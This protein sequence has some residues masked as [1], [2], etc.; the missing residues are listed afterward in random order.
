[1]PDTSGFRRDLRSDVEAAIAGLDA[2]IDVTFRLNE[3]GIRQQVRAALAGLDEAINVRLN[4]EDGALRADL[5]ALVERAQAGVKARVEVTWGTSATQLRNELRLL[6]ARAQAGVRAEVEVV[7]DRTRIPDLSGGFGGG[8]GF[9]SPGGWLQI[10]G[11]MALATSLAG[12]LVAAGAAVT[13]AWGAVS[14]TIAAIPVAIAAIAIPAAT[15]FLGFDELKNQFSAL[16]PVIDTLKASVSAVF[17]RELPF[18][19]MSSSFALLSLRGEF[20]GVALAIS[21]V[22]KYLL[23]LATQNSNMELLS[24]T[25][26][27]AEYAVRG[28]GVAAGAL[29]EAFVKVTSMK[30][31]WEALIDPIVSFSIRFSDMINRLALSGVLTNAFVGLEEVLRSLGNAFVDL[32]ENGIRVFATAAPGVAEFVDKLAAFFNRFDWEKLGAAVSKVFTGIAQ[33][34]SGVDQATI[35]AIVV[36]FDRLGDTFMDP[37]IQNG[38]K[39]LVDAIPPFLDMINTMISAFSQAAYGLSGF[40][41]AVHGG[42]SNLRAAIQLA[43]GEIT[44]TEFAERFGQGKDEVVRGMG[45]MKDAILGNVPPLGA[46]TAQA[47]EAATP[48]TGTIFGRWAEEVTGV[49][50][51]VGKNLSPALIGAFRDAAVN[52]AAPTPG[53]VSEKW[54]T[55]MGKVPPTISGVGTQMGAAAMDAARQ[56]DQNTTNGLTPIPG[57]AKAAL[58]PLAVA[59]KPGMNGLNVDISAG[60]RNATT[61][62]TTGVGNV[63]REAGTTGPKVRSSVGDLSGLLVA[64]GRSVMDG[65][66]NGMR[67]AAGGVLAYARSI[68]AQVKAVWPFS[69]AKDPKSPFAGKDWMKLSGQRMMTDWGKGMAS[70]ASDAVSAAYGVASEVQGRFN[71]V[72]PETMAVTSSVA[73]QVQHAVTPD[74]SLQDQILAA[75]A[76]FTVEFDPEG[77]VRM[78]NKSNTRRDRRG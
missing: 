42:A 56:V 41:Q 16:V 76:G 14:T 53:G 27:N 21:D 60:W 69:P 15:V 57:K 78:V 11:Y 63:A 75:L 45:M 34:L 47:T 51:E 7:V 23:V 49:P 35:D 12:P 37:R 64:A 10:V 72:I 61:T 29:Y 1:M 70:G 5:R 18:A 30:S 32:V 39:A 62:T 36:A 55:E 74:S 13:A 6:V 48:K 77:V 9:M 73:S 4:L 8:G 59:A 65:L 46:A 26:A 52:S 40:V 20:D 54:A 19:I 28:M 67:G 33:T 38:F 71:N 43:K 24:M 3:E 17:A 68:A 66:L 58:D 2:E 44:F 31:A 25:F 50:P 22:I